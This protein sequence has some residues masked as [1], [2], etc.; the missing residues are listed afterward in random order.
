VGYLRHRDKFVYGTATA[1]TAT[2][3]TLAEAKILQDG[4]LKGSTGYIVSGT[5]SGQQ[6]RVS[7]NATGTGVV[8]YVASWDVT[9]ST[10]SVV[11]HWPDNESPGVVNNAI[12]EAIND[13]QDQAIVKDVDNDPTLDADRKVITPDTTFTKVFAVTWVDSGGR[14]YRAR[15]VNYVDELYRLDPGVWAFAALNGDLILC[16][17]IPDDVEGTDINVHGYR[18][19]NLL[20][21]DSDQAE[22]RSDYLVYKAAVLLESSKIANPQFDPEGH[23]QRANVWLREVARAYPGLNTELEPSTVDL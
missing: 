17:A 13:S 5:G 10:D 9:P 12:N 15:A 3:I 6:N 23:A 4:A 2:T 8:T 7:T 18:I 20:S 22:V 16:Q 11:E 14:Y 19:P 1:A 21:S